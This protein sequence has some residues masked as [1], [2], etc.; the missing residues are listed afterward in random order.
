M[1]GGGKYWQYCEDTKCEFWNDYPDGKYTVLGRKCEVCGKTLITEK[2][3]EV[4]GSNIPSSSNSLPSSGSNVSTQ[5]TPNQSE[6]SHCGEVRSLKT[7]KDVSTK[8]IE[9]LNSEVRKETID[10]AQC[11]TESSTTSEYGSRTQ[12]AESY[13]V[14]AD[15]VG[16]TM[17]ILSSH[18]GD[19]GLPYSSTAGNNN[20][21]NTNTSESE[22]HI[23][24][25][26]ESHTDNSSLHFKRVTDTN[27]LPKSPKGN[28][29]CET[30]MNQ[31]AGKSG[32]NN[33]LK[34]KRS[35]TEAN[36]PAKTQPLGK[37]DES[38]HTT[39]QPLPD[40]PYILS[41][42]DP[43]ETRYFNI[44]FYTL[45]LKEYWKN[46]YAIC[47][48]ISGKYFNNFQTSIV[49][50]HKFSEVE[51]Q[52]GTFVIIEGTLRFPISAIHQS[53]ICFAYKYY[54]YLQDGQGNYE[55]LHH[56][57]DVN[58]YF[59]LK[60][61]DNERK[62]RIVGH[63]YQHYDIMILPDTRKKESSSFWSNIMSTVSYY[64]TSKGGDIP[65]YNINERKLISLQV[66]LPKYYQLGHLMP[67]TLLKDFISKFIFEIN[68]F[69][70]F[71]VQDYQGYHSSYIWYSYDN[72][73]YT[74][75]LPEEWIIAT[76]MPDNYVTM[77]PI[78]I[79]HLF[80]SACYLL[81]Y[82]N[83]DNDVVIANLINMIEDSIV[84]ILMTESYI[85]TTAFLS[86]QNFEIFFYPL[87]ATLY[88][89]KLTEYDVLHEALSYNKSE[90]WGFPKEETLCC[91]S[92]LPFDSCKPIL[93]LAKYDK[94]L[95]YSIVI[96]TLNEKNA[97][98]ICQHFFNDTQ[99]CPLSA[100]MSALLF[101]LF[102][103]SKKNV[104]NSGVKYNEKL[105]TEVLKSLRDGF[106]NDELK[107]ETKDVNRLIRL[108]LALTNNLPYNYFNEEQFQLCLQL[109]S[110]GIS[111]WDNHQ[112][113][114]PRI[115][116][117]NLFSSFIP[118]WYSHHYYGKP[119]QHFSNFLPEIKF[120]EQILFNIQ[121][122]NYYKFDSIIEELLT[123][124]FSDRN[125][126]QQ[127]I[128]D[129]FI[130][131]HNIKSQSSL[132]QD[133]FLKEL[134][135]RLQVKS[136]DRSN[137]IKQL[138]Q[139]LTDP[140]QL[141][142][143][144]TIFTKILLDEER[145][146]NENPIKHF[147]NW[148]SWDTY[149]RLL[150]SENIHQILSPQAKELLDMA[151]VQLCTV[152]EQITKLTITGED[153]SRIHDNSQRFLDLFF[154]VK[155]S[156][157]LNQ[158][159][160]M[161]DDIKAKM[162]QCLEM[163][164]W[165]LQ[166][167]NFLFIFNEFL[168]ELRNIH[169]ENI[170]AFLSLDLGKESINSICNRK[171]NG[172]SFAYS[173]EINAIIEF[174][175]FP[176]ICQMCTKLS[177]SRIIIGYFNEFISKN[178]DIQD[179]P[180]KMNIFYG[181]I[182][183][184]AMKF[185]EN[186]LHE[187][188]NQTMLISKMCEY[189]TST[190]TIEEI[191]KELVALNNGCNQSD[192]QVNNF[193][194]PCAEKIRQYFDLQQCSDGAKIIIQL[195][196]AFSIRGNFEIVEGL[197]NIK[198]TFQSK[199]LSSV[200]SKVSD[201][202]RYLSSLTNSN[203]EV[204]K[205]IIDKIEFIKWIQTN[206]KDINELKT[207]ID[208]SLTT[209]GGNPVDV[210]RITCLSSVCTNFAPLIFQVD[211][212][213][214][215]ETLIDR[216]KQVIESVER[217]KELT[218]L[219]RQV[220][221]NVTLWEEMKQSHGSVEETTLVQL[222]SII[223]SGV[224]CLKVG[225]SLNVS[226][227]VSLSVDRENDEKR[228][229]TL[230]QLREFRS[231]LMLVVS[232]FE[233]PRADVN[234]N[235]YENSQLF[236]HKLDTI[237]EIATIVIKLAESGNQSY[238]NYKLTSNFSEEREI[239]VEH[240]NHVK[241]LI[242][243]WKLKVE[244]VRATHY[245]LNYYT[246][247]Q[248]VS[249]QK[250]VNSFIADREDRELE[251]LYH[252]LRLLN[253]EV[254]KEDIQ[255]ALKQPKISHLHN[256]ISRT[257][258]TKGSPGHAKQS[259]FET[260]QLSESFCNKPKH[261]SESMNIELAK[262]VSEK[263]E[264]DLKLTI[265]GIVEIQKTEIV[266]EDSLV[267]WCI[268]HDDDVDSESNNDESLFQSEIVSPTHTIV[269]PSCITETL[270]NSDLSSPEQTSDFYQLGNFLEEIFRSCGT[271][272][273]AER[274]LPYN[275]KP[276]TPNLVVIP[277]Q[278]ILEFV[279]SL[280]MSDN[281][282]L[283]LP[284]Y[285]EVLICTA[286][287]KIE[288]I[289]I[290]WRRAMINADKNYM[291]IFC[292]V[293]VE[294]LNYEVAVLA[295]S[296][297]K[298]KLQEYDNRRSKENE[299]YLYK[300][301]LGESAWEVDDKKSRVRFVVS[302]SVGA[303]KSLKIQKI[304]SDILTH[305]IVRE[306][307]IEQAA[308]T[309]A[310][311]GKQASEE[312]LAEQLLS[313]NI[314][315]M[316]HGV[317]F[318]VDI[319]S[320]VQWGLEP[321]LFKLLVL[322]GISKSTGEF[323][324]CRHKDYYVVEI[325]LTSDQDALAK[326]SRLFPSIQC[327]QPSDVLGFAGNIDTQIIDLAEL[328]SEQ[329][330]RVNAYLER[331]GDITELDSFLF[332]SST[333]NR[334]VSPIDTM[335][336]I[337]QHCD[338]VQPS[339][340][341]LRNFVSFLDK[342][343][344]DCDNSD[345]CKFAAMGNEWKGFK[346][347]VVNFMIHMSKDFAT[348]SL[349]AENRQSMNDELN[350]PELIDQRRWENNSHPYIFFNPD[351]HTMTFLGFHISKQGHLLDSENP[352]TT[353]REN[354]I[355]PNLVELLHANGVKFREDYNKLTKIE[356]V[357]KMAGVM[358]L[359]LL[360]DPDPGYVLTLDNMRKIL[361]I[362]MRFRCNIPVVIMGETGCGKTRLIQFMCSLQALETGATNMLIL[363]VHGGTTEKDVMTK[364]EEA[365]VLAMKNFREHDIDTVLFFDEANT[366]PAIGLIKEIMCDRRMYG[367]HIRSDIRLQFI[368]A[369]NP[370]RRHT[371]EML[372]KLSTAGLGFFTKSSETTDRLGDIPL[373]ELVY[374]VMELPASL[375]PLVWD[376]GQLS[377]NIENTYT[378]EI[379]VKY[380]RDHNSPIQARD[381]IVDVISSV[382]A[383]AQCYMRERKDECSFVS[384]RDIERA[385][386]V[387]LWF[388]DVLDFFQ[389]DDT[390]S[391]Y[392]Y[393][394][395]ANS[396]DNSIDSEGSLE[397]GSPDDDIQNLIRIHDILPVSMIVTKSN[398]QTKSIN[399]I[400]YITYSLI[401]SLAVCY[402]AKLQEREEFD[403][404]IVGL[405]QHPL[406]PIKDHLIIHKEVDRCQQ[407]IL[408]EMTVGA[409]IAKNNALKENVF[410]MFVC[411]E[412]KIPLFVIGKPGSSKSLAKS[413][414]SNSMQGSRSPDYSILRHFKEVQIM[415][416][417]CS[418]LSTAEGIIGVFKSC[419]NLQRKTGSN[420]FAA[421]VVLDEVGL[422]EDSPLLPLKVLH[423]LLEDN[424]YESEEIEKMSE[425]DELKTKEIHI[426]VSE[427]KKPSKVEF[428]DMKDRVAF[429]GISNWSLDPAKMNRGIMV[430]RGDPDVDELIASAEG[431]CK[432]DS[433]SGKR[434]KSIQVQI[435]NLSQA[436]HKLTLDKTEVVGVSQNREYYG[437][438]DFYSLIKMLVFICNEYKTLLSPGILEH[439]VKR[440]FGGMTCVD[441]VK[442]FNDIV[443]IPRKDTN[444]C[445]DSSPLGLIRANLTNL[446]RSYHGETRYLLL[447]TENYA[448]LNILLRS[449]DMW[450]KLQDIRNIRVIFGSSFPC[451]QEYSAVCRNINRIKVCMES[452]KTII[453]LNLENLYESLYDALNQY[454]M[455]MN[456]QRYVDLGLGTHRMKCR[457]HN[458]FKLI[459]VADT[460][461]VQE[462]FPTPL[463]NRLE[464]HFL[465]MSTVLSE[466]EM[467][468]SKSLTEWANDFSTL[469]KDRS[470]GFQQRG[471]FTIGDCFI[472]YHD[473]TSSSIVFH[474]MKEMYPANTTSYTNDNF[475]DV[476]ERCK[477][478]LLRMATTDAVFRVKN[479][480]L[481]CQYEEIINKYFKSCQSSLEGYL[482]EALKC[483]Q[484]CGNVTAELN[485]IVSNGTGAHLTLATTHSRLLTEKDVDQLKEC[486]STDSDT[487]TIEITSISLQ[488]FQT[489]QQY[490]CEIQKFLRGE[491]EI[492]TKEGI[493]RKILLVQCER[494]A[495]N[496]KLIACAR[497]KAVDE[498]KDWREEKGE[499][500][501]EVCLVFLIQLSR[502]AHG[503]KFISFC[504]GDWNT[505]HIDDI[506][507]FDSIHMLPIS[508][509]IR[510]QI[511]QVFGGYNL[512]SK[513]Y[514]PSI[515]YQKMKI[516][517]CI[518]SAAS[519]LDDSNGS[520]ERTLTRI[521]DFVKLFKEEKY[522]D[523]FIQ[524]FCQRM[525]NLL[526]NQYD[527]S[528]D[529][530]YDWILQTANCGEDIKSC[531]TFHKAVNLRINST[532]T[533]LLS[534]LIAFI[535]RNANFELAVQDEK[536][537]RC[538][539]DLWCDIFKDEQLL[540]FQY[541]D[542]ISSNTF[543][544]RRKVPVLSDG[545]GGKFF[546][547][548]FPFSW[549]I[550]E[551]CSLLMSKAK[552]LA[553]KILPWMH[554]ESVFNETP[555]G[556]LIYK[557]LMS[558][559]ENAKY[560]ELYLR[561]FI[562]MKVYPTSKAD[563]LVF[564]CIL[565]NCIHNLCSIDASEGYEDI[566][567]SANKTTIPKIHYAYQD[568]RQLI[569]LFEQAFGLK[570]TLG[571]TISDM[572]PQMWDDQ[573]MKLNC[574]ELVLIEEIISLCSHNKD[575][576]SSMELAEIYV[577]EIRKWQ[578]LIE[579]GLSRTHSNKDINEYQLEIRR[580]WNR[581]IAV[582]L[583][584]S[585]CT[586]GVGLNV[587]ESSINRLFLILGES[588][589][590]TSLKVVNHI[591]TIISNCFKKM[592]KELGTQSPLRERFKGYATRFFIS[593]LTNLS[594]KYLEIE[595]D[596]TDIIRLLMGFV[597][598]DETTFSQSLTEETNINILTKN[599]LDPSPAFRTFL[600]QLLIKH[601]HD[602]FK[603]HI[604][605]YL[606]DTVGKFQDTL[607]QRELFLLIVQSIEDLFHQRF[608]EYTQEHQ[609]QLVKSQIDTEIAVNSDITKVSYE[610]LE[611][612]GTL[613]FISVHIS[614][615]IID[616]YN[617]LRTQL[618]TQPPNY[619]TERDRLITDFK[620]MCRLEG[621][622]YL[623]LFLLK[624]IYHQLG[625]D[626]LQLIT[627]ND[628][629]S[630]II[631]DDVMDI[632]TE[633]CLTDNCI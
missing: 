16:N 185:S 30:N 412:L 609:H 287:T 329:Y 490:T 96:Y 90:Y 263:A 414:I 281:D 387:M 1:S 312:H 334:G 519:R 581:I 134:T 442:I 148:N 380:L 8:P 393:Q 608:K 436:Y 12:V 261:S 488:Q 122:P 131:L 138:S 269:S 283:P 394:G 483:T 234:T 227:V 200:D 482:R 471:S 179:G 313:R 57:S 231:K 328:R 557:N 446:S 382:L 19:K 421:C 607:K 100:I 439:A 296:K 540:V 242:G 479:S 199:E 338:I 43:N 601:R 37:E 621:N 388:F 587:T 229:Y 520:E 163:N 494:G 567:Y 257:N 135:S 440:N 264:Y 196:N 487:D 559:E 383:G 516:I 597:S 549:L 376:F 306:D 506:R 441:P 464:K 536:V 75:K 407:L 326:F 102:H 431:I 245:Y 249:L 401:L 455:E 244:E 180:Y 384:L 113:N 618:D 582:Q 125:I 184:P 417:Q 484:I 221:E 454:Y 462:R 22:T 220:G 429:I 159:F 68:K 162:D 486:L 265:K 268:L 461:T 563:Y 600:L 224:L 470:L 280:Y 354:I 204:I 542:T 295:V 214:S 406:T 248:I 253:P 620:D 104:N 226:D 418:Q 357:I 336:R 5:H 176:S 298:I 543:L 198:L 450:P 507:S 83:I 290:F 434:S 522:F 115:N 3:T 107:L 202:A 98:R 528:L 444:Q 511:Y 174:P 588:P 423:P 351:K 217:N 259:L 126:P 510:K 534:E 225:D 84:N 445:P 347:F 80:Y 291:Y 62:E 463:I 504:G 26:N 432:F 628:K 622:E 531:G 485:E 379:V 279:L 400:D 76:S 293:N 177:K 143:L 332:Q 139:Q 117:Q 369:C 36:Q 55:N 403:L 629:C 155:N 553:G 367:R 315:G 545:A 168:E 144:K 28:M 501:F 167:Q 262:S 73:N 419:K 149:F 118:N 572:L 63:S 525:T 151:S 209:C 453:L 129:L 422:A 164:K 617:L 409:N 392:E 428:D 203:L 161:A 546:R 456:N 153:L 476:F 24:R 292:L 29:S 550:Q 51:L 157:S 192:I 169:H 574:L 626:T 322:G 103:S 605:E 190:D 110:R 108:T 324:H 386:R 165:I 69:V 623:H 460:E 6:I 150:D 569:E 56:H 152:I 573:D 147:V 166:Q 509:L 606:T 160:S 371:K 284:Y 420:K 416:Y 529:S 362:V 238:I 256:S 255:Q 307:E 130:N 156:E 71:Y 508:D 289:D 535:D 325:T 579:K 611:Q 564:E 205:A 142:K 173:D 20:N 430:A 366:S 4:S 624:N 274:Q 82:Y 630:W 435:S 89:V 448:A 565:L 101:R 52:S 66:L 350:M 197:G 121:F 215:Y 27:P 140:N 34:R 181:E 413:I 344:Y 81:E 633:V 216:C 282:K 79:I 136:A 578:P 201:T 304:Q 240:E 170:S 614:N 547:A 38:I 602:F 537:S 592:N 385:M 254:T 599:E 548:N 524:P 299:T 372:N 518:Q 310:I 353:I 492:E 502:E 411:I 477:T 272:M 48:R 591:L 512:E 515:N 395:N 390:V 358:D 365:E 505:V 302:D 458:E 194:M 396:D 570:D 250:G 316:E 93:G 604:T 523:E 18:D 300:L 114:T 133:I 308:V 521:G 580:K 616:C 210:D 297:F 513:T 267:E 377:N 558:N 301:V 426:P 228:I 415:S 15:V 459:V 47:L 207:F 88:L 275:L 119:K 363:K 277:S 632:I 496:A 53:K 397:L 132:L 495:D 321:I 404:K 171:E 39:S 211:E 615:W 345:Y 560:I 67:C 356:K 23:T 91:Q 49:Q 65:F 154:I 398:L 577:T 70:Y 438:R 527:S 193:L 188:I 72:Q 381:D 474:L 373:R 158:Q 478:L 473:D 370:Y 472:G 467:I 74:S 112:P 276:G 554:F 374:R 288:E 503:S 99:N 541:A 60:F 598:L 25:E 105:V 556:K 109:L 219:L 585:H 35:N 327:V 437:L 294:S 571:R 595:D 9:N 323:W 498:L 497:H 480:S 447:L 583:F 285:H 530:S 127:S 375:R 555:L 213:T 340:A 286:Q 399:Q 613:R 111:Y 45:I 433:Q 235:S 331:S 44:H 378:R 335:A 594:F 206:L 58:R 10:T 514:S 361:A 493:H 539:Y 424:D 568:S 14:P 95:P 309:V 355:N 86:R 405:F 7:N 120:W 46:I 562:Y 54:L 360:T 343:L 116:I 230:E 359:D 468:I 212:N 593:I 330:Q 260:M 85:L 425:Q 145:G 352:S 408:D 137:C 222:D 368:A 183:I 603:Q 246:I 233:Q 348:P 443:K 610:L 41:Q 364:V 42:M 627:K 305:D 391:E 232:K 218:E 273:R 271:K 533:P 489:E 31:Q 178:R 619:F 187:L 33:Q 270:S 314:C 491:T 449:Q 141:P 465:T 346:N 320:T 11:K 538:Y 61:D 457:V 13:R 146:F 551:N 339:W 596:N 87:F 189:F 576:T 575:R 342:Q 319:A 337:I 239:L 172:H 195:K 566:R 94:L 303:G 251:Q 191:M 59:N 410:M 128:I 17:P 236:T 481:S 589:D 427:E 500:M 586:L 561:D 252:L 317:M 349:K 223:K 552:N 186:T 123:K 241:G 92:E 469:D 451:D 612:I 182:W 341:E 466:D 266:T 106:L 526:K 333:S 532:I 544:P 517:E 124:R 475:V 2:P 175:L 78:S 311:H 32:L 97:S 247:A 278:M 590:F 208:I 40:R 21:N 402:R 318:H 625:S 584:I 64:T 237:T 50:F 258:S 77:D 389:P 452:G 631:P 499:Y 243:K